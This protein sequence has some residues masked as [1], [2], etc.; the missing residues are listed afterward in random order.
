LILVNT[1]RKKYLHPKLFEYH[2][3]RIHFKEDGPS[4]ESSFDNEHFDVVED[5]HLEL[6]RLHE[7]QE[8]WTKLSVFHLGAMC[9]LEQVIGVE[10]PQLGLRQLASHGYGYY[11]EMVYNHDLAS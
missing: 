11:R 7:H 2:R 5:E 10:G 3:I 6:Q 9:L 8:E 4:N 1:I